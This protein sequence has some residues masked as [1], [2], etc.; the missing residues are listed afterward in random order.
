L[1]NRENLKAYVAWISICIIWGTTYLAIRVGVGDLP[2]F[3]FAGFRWILAGPILLVILLLSG[4][5]FPKWKDIKHLA[6]V[7]ILLLG[8]GNGLVVFAEQWIPSGLTAILIT[9]LPFWVVGIESLL[10]A[11]TRLNLKIVLG[12]ILGISGTAIIFAGDLKSLFNPEYLFGALSLLVG[13]FAWSS[14][15]VYSKYKK[16]DTSPLMGASI[17]M[18]IAGTAQTIIGLSIG[19]LPRFVLTANGIYAYLYLLVFGSFIAYGAYM[20]AIQKLPLSLVSTYAYVNPV[21][22]LFLGWLILD[23][24]LNLFIIAGSII[25]LLGVWIVKRGAA[26][27]KTKVKTV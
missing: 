21:I 11:G 9:T 6:V 12:L 2:P 3:L 18:I 14:G 4:K 20:Y 8:I 16:V 15:T 22:A 19:E 24:N 27:Q 23:E 17:Q 25:I 13:V 10:P 7:G 5:K 1:N 26:V